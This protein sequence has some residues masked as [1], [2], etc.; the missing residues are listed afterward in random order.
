MKGYILMSFMAL[1]IMLIYANGGVL[2][3]K[4]NG[5]LAQFTLGNIGQAM[6]DCVSQN[7]GIN[8]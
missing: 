4:K 3:D 8:V 7:V 2:S 6:A 5:F 1:F